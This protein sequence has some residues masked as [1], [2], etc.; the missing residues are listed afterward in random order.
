MA[1][2]IPQTCHIPQL[3]LDN[4]ENKPWDDSPLTPEG[5]IKEFCVK[6]IQKLMEKKVLEEKESDQFGKDSEI[7]SEF[8]F[9]FHPTNILKLKLTKK[10]EN[11]FTMILG[12]NVQTM[13]ECV[14]HLA[15]HTLIT[16]DEEKPCDGQNVEIQILDKY[17][18]VKLPQMS[19][20]TKGN[21]KGNKFLEPFS[22]LGVQ[23][24]LQ[25]TNPTRLIVL[26]DGKNID[27]SVTSLNTITPI[28]PLLKLLELKRERV[29]LNNE[30]SSILFLIHTNNMQ[31][32]PSIESFNRYLQANFSKHKLEAKR[33]VDPKKPLS[34]PRRHILNAISH[35]TGNIDEGRSI[36]LTDFAC[37]ESAKKIL[38]WEK[39]NAAFDKFALK[40]G[41]D[42][43][44]AHLMLMLTR[45]AKELTKLFLQSEIHL[46]KL[47]ELWSLS[48]LIADFVNL[49]QLGGNNNHSTFSTFSA[50]RWKF[51]DEKC[52]ELVF[53]IDR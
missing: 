22:M 24:A 1:A 38:E 3:K 4:V 23:I 29:N 42:H 20:I 31:E 41:S 7:L 14:N 16:A 17:V 27:A 34:S 40:V 18:C 19:E 30:L 36:L 53:P 37:H 6:L 12:D 32:P 45:A 8:H 44:D 25:I 21:K 52:R 28:D 43:F 33:K 46:E 39:N 48:N 47:N 50:A 51:I 10:P 15:S 35:L 11:G 26:C 5:K 2:D 13:I 9:R 49:Y